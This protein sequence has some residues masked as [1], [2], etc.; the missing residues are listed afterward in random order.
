MSMRDY[1]AADVFGRMIQSVYRNAKVY[2]QVRNM[3]NEQDC[4]TGRVIAGHAFDWAEAFIAEQAAR[5]A[6]E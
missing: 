1:V 4:T 6:K 2:Q 3:A 5:D